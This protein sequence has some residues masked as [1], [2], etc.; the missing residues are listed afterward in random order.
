VEGSV[1]AHD[2]EVRDWAGDRL[3]ALASI[4][5]DRGSLEV[6][7]EMERRFGRD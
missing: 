2:C 6:E 5:R 4:F 3:L 7:A 1:R